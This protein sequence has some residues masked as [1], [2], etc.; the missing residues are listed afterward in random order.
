VAQSHVIFQ[1]HNEIENIK[2]KSKNMYK[3]VCD[4]TSLV[5]INLEESTLRAVIDKFLDSKT[6]RTDL[7][8]LINLM[9]FWNKET[10][11]IYIESFDLFRLKTGVILTNGNLSRAI[12]SLEEKGFI[13]KVGTHNK[14]EYLFRIPLQLLNE[15]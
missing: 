15:S 4:P 13:L 3:E 2:T 1:D 12:K 5:Y 14:L 8:V 10:S 9:D 11:F 7:N 6:S